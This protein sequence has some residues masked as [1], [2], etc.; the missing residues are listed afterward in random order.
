M[1]VSL[2]SLSPLKGQ[3]LTD[4]IVANPHLTSEQVRTEIDRKVIE[5]SLISYTYVGEVF[6]VLAEVPL[7]K[8]HMT[9]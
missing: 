6:Y 7:V 1:K 2:E 8:K 9:I 5:G 3:R 4:L